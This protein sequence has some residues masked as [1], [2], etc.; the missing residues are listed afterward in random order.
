VQKLD[1]TQIVVALISA[2]AVITAAVIGAGWWRSVSAP[3]QQFVIAG[4]VVDQTSNAAIGQARI[5]L[6]GRTESYV[7]DDLGNFRIELRGSLSGEQRIRIHVTKEGYRPYDEAVTPS[8]ENLVI[9][10]KKL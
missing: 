3:R 6:S 5:S 8:V 7:T 4:V 10:L 1:K 2:T 9:P